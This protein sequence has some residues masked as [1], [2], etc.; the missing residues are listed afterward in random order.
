MLKTLTTRECQ[1][2]YGRTS[3]VN[4]SRCS[5]NHVIC[6]T[7]KKRLN[8]K[9]CLFCQ[10]HQTTETV[11]Q[12]GRD[13]PNNR[14]R[15]NPIIPARPARPVSQTSAPSTVEHQDSIIEI[16][17]TNDTHPI[18]GPRQEQNKCIRDVCE[19][20][21]YCLG[22]MGKYGLGFMTTVYLGKVYFAFFYYCNSQLDNSWISWDKFDYILGEA[23]CGFIG[24]IIL[25]SCCCAR[26]D[27]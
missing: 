13:I 2:C 17:R 18:S 1:C 23:F 20:L 16:T 24:S 11:R 7:C 27:G 5:K 25:Y 3:I 22:K 4:S 10:P 21:G 9:D 15:S 8:R 12:I 6:S 26:N 14:A 19:C